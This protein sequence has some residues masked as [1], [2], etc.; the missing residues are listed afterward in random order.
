M[1]LQCIV[2]WDYPP[3]ILGN[4][5]IAQGTIVFYAS[6]VSR[7]CG[8]RT[9]VDNPTFVHSHDV[10]M[11]LEL[12]HV[13]F[14]RTIDCVCARGKKVEKNGENGEKSRRSGAN[15]AFIRSNR[16]GAPARRK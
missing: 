15:A 6:P 16:K 7:V 11:S 8:N 2:D 14:E 13:G 10:G 1:E 9:I 12:D 3:W 4:V 5:R